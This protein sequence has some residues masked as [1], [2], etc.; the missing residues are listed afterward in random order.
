MA[1]RIGDYVVYGEISNLRKNTTFG[2]LWLRGIQAP[3]MVQLLGDMGP[4]LRGRRLR[5]RPAGNPDDGPTARGLKFHP[6]QVGPTG[7]MLARMVKRPRNNAPSVGKSAEP[8]EFEWLP[9]LYLEWFSQNGRIVL[10]LIDPELVVAEGPPI[11]SPEEETDD[12]G[13]PTPGPITFRPIPEGEVTIEEIDV[14]SLPGPFEDTENEEAEVIDLF[15]S[16]EEDEEDSPLAAEMRNN[17]TGEVVEPEDLVSGKHQESDDLAGQTA[18]ELIAEMELMDDLIDNEPGEFV[19]SI[20]QPQRLPKPEEVDEAQAEAL[21]KSLAM[22]LATFGVALDVCEHFTMKQAYQYMITELI[23]E[24]RVHPEL[25]GTGWVQ[26]FMTSESCEVC[27][28]ETEERAE[29]EKQESGEDGE[30]NEPI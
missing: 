13:R 30:D 11:P 21:V 19:G 3:V 12:S 7:T 18:E 29:R 8:V 2:Y 10:E 27:L 4:Q 5:F 9:C 28:R 24:A 14:E 23:P 16:S 15:G 20:L 26:H 6:Q 17:T 1:F 25:R 22:E